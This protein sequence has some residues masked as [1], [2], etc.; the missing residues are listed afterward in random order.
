VT[1][2]KLTVDATYS[3]NQRVDATGG[4]TATGYFLK[5]GGF[6]DEIEKPGTVFEFVNKSGAP[7]IDFSKLP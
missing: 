2:A 6:F 3:A 5:M 7:Q 4:K 1:G